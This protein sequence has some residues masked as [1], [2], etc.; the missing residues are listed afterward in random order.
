EPLPVHRVP[1]GPGSGQVRGR[2]RPPVSGS[3]PPL[4]GT[5]ARERERSDGRR[6]RHIGRPT[7][8]VEHRRFVRGRGRYINDLELPGMLHLGVVPA[9]VAH[10]R[11]TLV[12]VSGALAAPGVVAVIT[13]ED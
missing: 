13:G 7:P 8:L 9:P 2:Q 6:L 10:A 3:P 1:A 5:S 12:D 11:L 4:R